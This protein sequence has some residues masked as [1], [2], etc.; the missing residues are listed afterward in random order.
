MIPLARVPQLQPDDAAIDAL[1][2]LSDT[3]ANRGVVLE[4]G[5]L[6]GI[7]SAADLGRALEV[8]PRRLRRSGAAD[9]DRRPAGRRSGL[10]KTSR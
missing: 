4:H 3:G 10:Q 8:R 6:V 9:E 7:I 5:R 2:A 1:V